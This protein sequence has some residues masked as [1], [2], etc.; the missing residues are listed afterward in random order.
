MAFERA[1]WQVDLGILRS[2]FAA[3]SSAVA[4]CRK[5]AVV[6]ADAY[7][8]GLMPV[9]C[10]IADMTDIFA[11]AELGEAI[12]VAKLGKP[13]LIFGALFGDEISEA[14]H[15][16]IIV[17]TGTIQEALAVN[18]EA[19]RQGV[20]AKVLIPVDTGMG[21]IGICGDDKLDEIMRIAALENLELSGIYTHCPTASIEKDAPT[22]MQLEKFRFL[23]SA[24]AERGVVFPAVHIAA[25]DAICNYPDACRKPFTHARV[26]V[27][28]YGA[29]PKFM[30]QAGL[31]SVGKFFSRLLE[32]RELP[33]G[34]SIGYGRTAVLKK[35]TLVG[36]VGCG[37][38]SGLPLAFSNRG[39][40]L[41]RGLSCP[42][43]GRV[44]MDYTTISLENL[45]EA[46]VGDEAVA[47]GSQGSQFI[48][49]AEWAE[50][51]NTHVHEVLC[52]ISGRVQRRYING[53]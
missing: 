13:V 17:P 47:L 6:K 35:T 12:E 8:F 11:V 43:L 30:P 25:S 19:A 31:R 28:M 45:P 34:T 33:A 20:K 4:P 2:N 16:N 22:V 46:Q 39:R 32:V 3:I 48:S 15:H 36:T 38:A 40:F 27:I 42:V 10:A 9:A 37:Y 50:L 7:G 51:K 44:S 41:V 14:V 18:T 26:G 24:L 52:S 1:V 5:I 23:V 21:R 49:A 53:K 29:D